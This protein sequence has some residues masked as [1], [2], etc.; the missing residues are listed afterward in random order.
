MVAIGGPR[1]I[2]AP[3]PYTPR[4]FG[5]LSAVNMRD[6]AG[7]PHWR[8]G[9]TWQ[10]WCADP[11]AIATFYQANCEGSPAPADKAGNVDLT[12]FAATAFTVYAQWDCSPVGYSETERQSM[13]RDALQRVTP[14]QVEQAFWTGSA[15]GDA[16]VVWPHLANNTATVDTGISPG[17]LGCAATPVTGVVLDIVEGVQRVEAAW[18]ACSPT[19]GQ[20][21]LHVPASLG[22]S[23]WQWNLVKTDGAQLRTQSGNL[24]VLGGGYPGTSP[25]GV[26]TA[27]VAWIYMSGP[28]FGYRGAPDTWRFSEMFDRETNTLRSLV[29]QT[30]LFGYSCCCTPAAAIS[31]GGDITGTPLSAT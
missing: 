7:D 12:L 15:G 17:L 8:G 24:V 11:A 5:L 9:V 30:W 20:G 23:L 14:F 1:Q 16:N 22:P 21:I 29:E 25:A 19:N 3:P 18:A 28:I 6:E 2:V 10:D 4:N 31:L 13:A 26:L 27:N